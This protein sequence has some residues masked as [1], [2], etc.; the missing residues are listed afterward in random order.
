M[1]DASTVLHY[2]SKGGKQITATNSRMVAPKSTEDSIKAK[3]AKWNKSES[4]STQNPL[5]KATHITKK[6]I[7]HSDG[8]IVPEKTTLRNVEGD[9]YEIR[10]GRYKGKIATFH[11]DNLQKLDEAI[12]KSS[13]DDFAKGNGKEPKNSKYKVEG[14]DENKPGGVIEEISTTLLKSYAK[15]ARE[16]ARKL[17]KQ[18]DAAKTDKTK[19]AKYVKAT[20]RHLNAHKAE[21]KISS[22]EFYGK[23]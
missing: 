9:K 17:S 14:I 1:N 12:N 7:R 2:R 4:S 10:S 6:D 16:D 22:N 13:V 11:P 21:D 23:K 19:L 3:L 8:G 5:E 18:G 15:K 20:K